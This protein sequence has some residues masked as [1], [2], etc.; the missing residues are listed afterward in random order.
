MIGLMAGLAMLGAAGGGAAGGTG[1]RTGDGRDVFGAWYTPDR[2]SVIA[3]ADCGDG[4][5]CGTV[6]WLDAER[7]Q[8]TIDEHN[9]DAGLRGR[10]ILG[11]T[12]LS[13]FETGRQG[14]GQGW[15]G[16]E[17]YHPGNGNT[18]RAKV[19]RLDADT[20]EVKGCVGPICKAQRWVRAPEAVARAD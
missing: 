11:I 2:D 4:T 8:V 14:S 1:D 7:A 13:G 18:Y 15:R 17:I 10:P 9:A 19:R 3:I 12:L 20:L 16:G 6:T 5:P